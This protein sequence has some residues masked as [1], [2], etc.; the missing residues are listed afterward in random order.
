M[1]WKTLHFQEPI[2]FN[3]AEIHGYK[4]TKLHQKPEAIGSIPWVSEHDL[5]VSI[6]KAQESQEHFWTFERFLMLSPRRH[7]F[8]WDKWSDDLLP[9]LQAKTLS[10]FQSFQR[11]AIRFAKQ[12]SVFEEDPWPQL[13]LFSSC[14][15]SVLRP[16]RGAWCVVMI[17]NHSQILWIH[18]HCIMLHCVACSWKFSREPQDWQCRYPDGPG[19][20][21]RA[22]PRLLNLHVSMWERAE[23]DRLR[24]FWFLFQ[25]I[26]MVF[27]IL[28]TGQ[29]VRGSNS[30]LAPP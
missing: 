10:C 18:I 11:E 27:Y 23:Q 2:W 29:F 7:L 21:C 24:F 12:F 5:K 8:C 22:G 4:E 28:L 3:S 9:P 19:N 16:S 30:L 14:Y 6:C 17:I 15:L 1:W 25:F 26:S 20:C 13:L